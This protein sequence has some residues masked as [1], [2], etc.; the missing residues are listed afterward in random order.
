MTLLI[1]SPLRPCPFAPLRYAFIFCLC[2]LGDLAVQL[3]SHS[4]GSLSHSRC[5]VAKFA[6]QRIALLFSPRLRQLGGSSHLIR[7]FL[8]HKIRHDGGCSRVS[9]RS[10]RRQ[11]RHHRHKISDFFHP[12]QSLNFNCQ[13]IPES[14]TERIPAP[15]FY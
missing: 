8:R 11:S 14:K 9:R 1:F 5:G 3:F 6:Q 2:A 4:G 13:L 7:R 12:I 15:P 10:I